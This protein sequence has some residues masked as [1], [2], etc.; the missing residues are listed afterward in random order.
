MGVFLDAHCNECPAMHSFSLILIDYIFLGQASCSCHNVYSH[1]Y[2]KMWAGSTLV[3]VRY[4]VVVCLVFITA[5]ERREWFIKRCSL[6][7]KQIYAS[8][9]N[10]WH[11]NWYNWCITFPIAPLCCSHHKIANQWKCIIVPNICNSVFDDL[12]SHIFAFPVFKWFH[13]IEFV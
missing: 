4:V 2:I 9:P 7:L 3:C 11:C 1:N 5:S 10:S 8:S 13:I 12:V 6:A